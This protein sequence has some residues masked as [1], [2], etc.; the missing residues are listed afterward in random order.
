MPTIFNCIILVRCELKKKTFSCLSFFLCALFSKAKCTKAEAERK[1]QTEAA[2][3]VLTINRQ[4]QF[5]RCKLIGHWRQCKKCLQRIFQRSLVFDHFWLVFRVNVCAWVH[6][7]KQINEQKDRVYHFRISFFFAYSLLAFVFGVP[8]ADFV[9]QI[10]MKICFT[11]EHWPE[12]YSFNYVCMFLLL[13]FN[14]FLLC[15]SCL[16]VVC[17]ILQLFHI[18]H[19]FPTPVLCKFSFHH[20]LLMHFGSLAQFDPVKLICSLFCFEWFCWAK[21]QM[22]DNE[23]QLSAPECSKST[24]FA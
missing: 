13:E 14:E 15:T 3:S 23:R 10:S 16:C 22:V 5:K 11:F 9:I 24:I 7:L 4:K 20:F 17:K 12:Q 6:R 21:R 1:V 18:D 8:F 19:H 2:V